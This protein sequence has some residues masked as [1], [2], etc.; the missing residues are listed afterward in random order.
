VISD[1][2]A[3][4]AAVIIVDIDCGQI[5]GMSLL[6]AIRLAANQRSR[7]TSARVR[8]ADRRD[9]DERGESGGG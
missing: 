4:C 7:V 8:R 6:P 1:S 5:S 3:P 2:N 9:Q